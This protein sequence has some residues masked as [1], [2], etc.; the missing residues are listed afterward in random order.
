MQILVILWGGGA[1][2]PNELFLH[3][4]F[5]VGQMIRGRGVESDLQMLSDSDKYVELCKLHSMYVCKLLYISTCPMWPIN[6]R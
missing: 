2:T 3:V 4:Y 1:I 6:C 5:A